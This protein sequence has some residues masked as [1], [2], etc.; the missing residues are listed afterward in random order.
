MT[1]QKQPF[2]PQPEGLVTLVTDSALCTLS[3]TSSVNNL[4]WSLSMPE[5]HQDLFNP[6]DEDSTS[7]EMEGNNESPTA[8]ANS[9]TPSDWSNVLPNQV[10]ARLN[11]IKQE[12]CE[13]YGLC[14]FYKPYSH[15]EK[16]TMDQRN[17]SVAWFC[18]LSDRLKGIM[19]YF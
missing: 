8:T 3:C 5:I 7:G 2:D 12:V 19:I 15:W 18:Q 14:P 17:K 9:T 1:Q 6:G 4:S 11:L 13:Q 16:T 10:I